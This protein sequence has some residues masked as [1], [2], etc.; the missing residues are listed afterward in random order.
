M[1]ELER[2]EILIKFKA[3]ESKERR[4]LL[5]DGEKKRLMAQRKIESK[6]AF[7]E[8]GE[9]VLPT[10]RTPSIEE[11]ALR[12]L[13][14]ELLAMEA[15]ATAGTFCGTGTVIGV[16]LGR[17]TV[18]MSS[19]RGEHD[20]RTA[21][22][23]PQLLHIFE[24]QVV[25]GDEVDLR[26]LADQ[27]RVTGIHTRKTYLSRPEVGPGTHEQMIVA[28]VDRIVIVVSVVAP[29]LHPRLIDRYLVAVTRGGA[30]PLLCVNKIDLCDTPEQLELELVS[31]EAYKGLDL[32]TVRVSTATHLGLDALRE[33]LR[34]QTCAFVGHSG[35]GKSSIVKALAPE[36]D[37]KVG[38][39][40]DG[41]ERGAHTTTSSSL[42][43]C[44]GD[45]RLIDTPGIRS[46]GL[47]AIP[48]EELSIY[49]PDFAEAAENCKYRDCK[50]D[51]EPDCGVRRAAKQKEIHPARYDTY[52]RLL[53]SI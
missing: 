15:Q 44:E 32:E 21:I 33:K 43:E 12:I 41:N 24:T 49:F 2:Q 37:L 14:D 30:K 19:N 6:R 8:D 25:V 28:N 11:F 50:H 4:R 1:T 16:Q 18:R 26:T 38:E 9:E 47:W 39:I 52:V 29:P 5:A 40:S 46:F 51:R 31:L 20:D 3:L 53:R 48:R 13:R 27:L 45:L 23:P 36:L 10:K 34:G 42:Y 17:C 22:I 7:N 35:V